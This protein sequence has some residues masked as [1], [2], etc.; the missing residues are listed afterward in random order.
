MP[1]KQDYTKMTVAQLKAALSAKGLDLTGRKS[2]LIERLLEHAE[3]EKEQ[4]NTCATYFAVFHGLFKLLQA[5]DQHSRHVTLTIV[6][7][8]RSYVA[9]SCSHRS[10]SIRCLS[11]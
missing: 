2:D 8:L 5:F 9:Y 7:H 1:A 4:G 11:L 10:N 3:P 6:V